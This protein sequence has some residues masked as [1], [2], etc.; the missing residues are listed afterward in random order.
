M[1]DSLEKVKKKMKENENFKM[2]MMLLGHV[3]TAE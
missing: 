1:V 3:F 2:P